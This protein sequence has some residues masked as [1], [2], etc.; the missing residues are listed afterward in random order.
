MSNPVHFFFSRDSQIIHLYQTFW[1]LQDSYST[2]VGCNT[3]FFSKFE[4]SWARSSTY[5][6][7]IIRICVKKFL[8]LTHDVCIWLKLKI[9]KVVYVKDVK[10]FFFIFIE[11]INIFQHGLKIHINREWVL[12]LWYW[13]FSMI[14]FQYIM[15]I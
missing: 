6:T 10:R 12:V 14:I 13:F 1:L 9:I 5:V 7:H 11:T 3:S 8:V 2:F 4:L 15:L